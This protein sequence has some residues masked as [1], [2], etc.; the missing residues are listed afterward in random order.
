M[1]LG[2]FFIYIFVNQYNNFG[3]STLSGKVNAPQLVQLWLAKTYRLVQFM[4]VIH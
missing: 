4:F 3:R 1:R 2:I